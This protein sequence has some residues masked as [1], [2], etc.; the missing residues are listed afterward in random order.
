MVVVT[1][2]AGVAPLAAEA[3][4]SRAGRCGR[5]LQE[6]CSSSQNEAAV[7]DGNQRSEPPNH[8]LGSVDSAE[9]SSRWLK[10]NR[11]PG[12]PPLWVC[13]SPRCRDEQSKHQ[14][15]QRYTT[16]DAMLVETY[17]GG[18]LQMSHQ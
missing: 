12:E 5:W 10:Q 14:M 2:A 4:G 3:G 18:H 15:R 7:G 1:T 17:L 6:G 13:L 9:G 11:L 16:E 8:S